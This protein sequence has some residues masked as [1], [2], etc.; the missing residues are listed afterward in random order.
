MSALVK[1]VVGI[2]KRDHDVHIQQGAHLYALFIPYSLNV[3]Q[4]DDFAS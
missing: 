1:G 2:E 4:C 3:R